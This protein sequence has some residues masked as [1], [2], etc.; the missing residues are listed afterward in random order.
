[1]GLRLSHREEHYR[2]ALRKVGSP[3][4]G[5]FPATVAGRQGEGH[6]DS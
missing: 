1:M 4:A 3:N 5:P 6:T 2:G